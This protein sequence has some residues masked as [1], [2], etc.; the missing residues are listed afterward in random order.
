VYPEWWGATDNDATGATN[1]VG[2]GKRP[3]CFCENTDWTH[4]D[5]A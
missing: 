5:D 2:G 1:T 4:G 3:T